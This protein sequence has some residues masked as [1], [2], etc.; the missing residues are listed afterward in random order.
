MMECI[1]VYQNFLEA[2]CTEA[3]GSTAVDVF[4]TLANVTAVRALS[5]PLNSFSVDLS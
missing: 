1:G 5:A 3:D 2:S 4:S